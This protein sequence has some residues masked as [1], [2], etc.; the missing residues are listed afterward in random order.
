MFLYNCFVFCSFRKFTTQ[1]HHINYISSKSISDM[2]L[3]LRNLLDLVLVTSVYCTFSLEICHYFATKMSDANSVFFLCLYTFLSNVFV[4]FSHCLLIPLCN[5]GLS[6]NR[7]FFSV[8]E[9]LHVLSGYFYA[10]SSPLLSDPF[11]FT[12][13]SKK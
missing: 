8:V 5:N 7:P 4:Y 3:M 6:E 11:T 1:S 10:N 9:A 12:V 13:Q 2:L